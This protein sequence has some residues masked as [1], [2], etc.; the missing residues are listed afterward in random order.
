MPSEARELDGSRSAQWDAL[1]EAH[2]LGQA[3]V[4]TQA[5]SW[6]AAS[7]W[8]MHP[9]GAFTGGTLVAGAAFC[10]KRIPF[11]PW[12]LGRIPA[13]LADARDV[14]GSTLTLLKTLDALARSLRVMEIE[15]Q[16]AIHDIK[17]PGHVPFY[18]GIA[19]AFTAAGYAMTGVDDGTYLVRIDHESSRDP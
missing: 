14:V 16:C 12:A 6:W 2:P 9:V 15:S 10:T 11:L 7:S 3:R 1:V 13:I 4:T 5:R 19:E 18:E 17:D 8:S